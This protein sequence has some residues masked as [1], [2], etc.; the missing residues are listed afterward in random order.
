MPMRRRFETSSMTRLARLATYQCTAG[1]KIFSYAAHAARAASTANSHSGIAT[2][3]PTSGTV[4][5]QGLLDS[6]I[7]NQP[8]ERDRHVERLS[9]PWPQQCRKDGEQVHDGRELAL[10]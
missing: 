7:G 10:P 6:A 3:S 2:A 4:A 1:S 8:K 9:H 5:V